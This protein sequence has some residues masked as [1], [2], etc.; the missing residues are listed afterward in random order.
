MSIQPY[1]NPLLQDKVREQLETI[2]QGSDRPPTM[3]DLNKMKYLEGVTNETTRLYP[4]VPGIFRQATEYIP[5]AKQR[6]HQYISLSCTEQV[7]RIAKLG[8]AECCSRKGRTFDLA[9]I[10]C[11]RWIQNTRRGKSHDSYI[12]RTSHGRAFPQPTEVRP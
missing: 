10:L 6:H 3:S 4:P 8:L 2:F 7:K 1:Y 12:L 5:I 9:F 11:F